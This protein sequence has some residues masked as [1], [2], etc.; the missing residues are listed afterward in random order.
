MVC[1]VQLQVVYSPSGLEHQ[2]LAVAM[3]AG[4]SN[5]AR[6]LDCVMNSNCAEVEVDVEIEVQ[7]AD[8][9]LAHMLAVV[10]GLL[11]ALEMRAEAVVAGEV[12][13]EEVLVAWFAR[14]SEAP[15]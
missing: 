14:T 12:V 13:V 4:H 8:K 5:Y 10:A 2:A 1:A 11:I 7:I 9:V 15:V 6:L 3:V